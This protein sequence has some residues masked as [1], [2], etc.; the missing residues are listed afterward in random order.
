MK[1]PRSMSIDE[2]VKLRDELDA[3]IDGKVSDER[4]A[5]EEKL[6]KLGGV[7]GRRGGARGRESSLKGRAVAPKYRNPNDPTQTWA[8]RGMQP[9]WLRDLLKKG[10]KLEHFAIKQKRKA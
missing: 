10:K 5:L 3:L 1:N 7:N 9:R 2:L 8:G 6:A 4:R